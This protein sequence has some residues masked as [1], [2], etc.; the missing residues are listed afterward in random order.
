VTTAAV[1]R[2]GTT[3][4]H[5]RRH[6]KEKLV[7]YAVRMI[8]RSAPLRVAFVF[9]ILFA[10]SASP[11]WG[12]ADA[13]S[14][15]PVSG[16][17]L[18]AASITPADALARVEFLRDELELIRFEMGQP[19]AQPPELKV[20]DASP[21]EVM[22][23]ASTLDLKA[24]QLV[25]ELTGER[26]PAVV[27]D[28]PREVR[29]L[30]VRRV[31]DLARNRTLI[32]KQALGIRKV[33]EEKP[34]DPSTTPSDVFNAIVLATRQLDLLIEQRLSAADVYH[35]VQQAT[36][37][38]ARLLGQFPDAELMPA[39]PEFEHGKRPVEV[40]NRLVECYRKIE[41]VTKRSGIETL[42]IRVAKLETDIDDP[43]QVSPSDGYNMAVLIVSELAYLHQALGYADV[44]TPR[45]ELGFKL[46]SDVY[47]QAGVLLAQLTEL[48]RLVKDN[49]GWLS[50]RGR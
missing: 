42:R 41:R 45:I 37:Y 39:T 2:R 25:F 40:F 33:V 16:R 3:P 31:V 38:A 30:N 5:D 1:R 50:A 43:A 27:M 8:H 48:D 19:R 35:Q 44:P 32:A 47:Q 18:D 28:Q 4:R 22:Y 15:D 34:Q 23:Q 36:H 46:P 13:V 12:Q 17:P 24:R 49:P 6:F 29:P 7:W 10:A 21:R 14:P 26:G 20:T 11:G 9:A